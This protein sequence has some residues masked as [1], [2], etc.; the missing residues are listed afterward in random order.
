MEKQKDALKE[1][2]DKM[3]NGL[4]DALNREKKMYEN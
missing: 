4:T 1:S 3:I 2:T